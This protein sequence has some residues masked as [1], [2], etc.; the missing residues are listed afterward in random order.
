GEPLTFRP[1]SPGCAM[2][3]GIWDIP[4]PATDLEVTPRTL[5]APLVGF[6]ASLYRL[7]YG[8]GFFDR[9]LAKIGHGAEV[10]GV[11]YAMF[12]LPSIL[13]QPHDIAMHRIVTDRSSALGLGTPGISPVCYADD[14]DPRYA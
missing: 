3:R 5:L 14:A 2:T 6:D 4:I 8:G 11:G 9:T 13:P 12:Q 10:I 1:W 7:G